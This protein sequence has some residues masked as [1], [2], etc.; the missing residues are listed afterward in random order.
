MYRYLCA[1]IITA[2]CHRPGYTVLGSFIEAPPFGHHI[3]LPYEKGWMY[4]T[5]L[6]ELS[7]HQVAVVPPNERTVD[8]LKLA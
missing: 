4:S 7:V 5:C 3:I 2:W 8:N 6:C 1:G